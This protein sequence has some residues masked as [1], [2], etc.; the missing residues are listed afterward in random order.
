[1]EKKLL[2]GKNRRHD[3]CRDGG[4]LLGIIVR[5]QTIIL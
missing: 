3:V 5:L 2:E 1:M 4:R